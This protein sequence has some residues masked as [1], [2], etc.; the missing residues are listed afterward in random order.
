MSSSQACTK[1]SEEVVPG[2]GSLRG[3]GRSSAGASVV[4]LTREGQFTRIEPAVN[5][6]GEAFYTVEHAVE[7]DQ[8]HGYKMSRWRAPLVNLQSTPD[9]RFQLCGAGLEPLVA[10][11]RSWLLKG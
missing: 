1:R 3:P 11:N 10:R 7:D 4:T 9:A 6:L 5:G 2:A 8:D